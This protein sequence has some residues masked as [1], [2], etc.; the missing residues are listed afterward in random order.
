MRTTLDLDE[1]LLKAAKSL[2]QSQGKSLG[3]VI[4]SLA[5]KGLEPRPGSRRRGGFP[6]FSVPPDATPL[7]PEL[8]GKAEE[9]G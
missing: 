3:R 7:T 5:R 9:E 4:S 1:D 6:T 8:V 2:A